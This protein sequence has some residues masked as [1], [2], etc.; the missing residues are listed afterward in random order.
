MVCLVTLN[1]NTCEM[2]KGTGSVDM[3]LELGRGLRWTINEHLGGS[4]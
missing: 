4:G 3:G 1:L 2:S